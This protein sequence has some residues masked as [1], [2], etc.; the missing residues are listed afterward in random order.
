ML[1]ISLRSEGLRAVGQSG[2][3]GLVQWLARF[4]REGVF[5]ALDVQPLGEQDTVQMLLACLAPPATDFAEWL[6]GDTHGHPFY[7]METLKDLLE[8]GA[9]RAKRRANG[10]WTFQV[11]ADHEL[12]KAVRVPST[13]GAVVRARLNR[14]SPAAFAL[15]AAGATLERGLTFARLVATASVSEEAGLPALDELVSSRLLVEGV[16]P[17]GAGA[18]TFPNDMVRDVVYTEAGDA[19]RHLFHRRALELLAAAQEPEAV[20]AHHALVAGQAE[21]AFAHSR[22]AGEAALR[23]LA[24]GEAIVH[25]E[26]AREVATEAALAGPVFEAELREVYRLL[27][28]AHQLAGEPAQA[29]AALAELKRP[30]NQ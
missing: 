17:A 3:G 16:L 1:L 30:G 12:G 18:Y 22:A 15:L 6:F 7:L 13:I 10:E 9:L 21:A 20:L 28:R 23:L 19:R 24:A 8:R 29:A 14:L 11:D 26:K 5:T 4:E 27:A 2:R 25:F